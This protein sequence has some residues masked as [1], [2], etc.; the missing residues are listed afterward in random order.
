VL[1]AARRAACYLDETEDLQRAGDCLGAALDPE[2]LRGPLPA[3]NDTYKGFGAGSTS[4]VWL[5]RVIGV[6]LLPRKI[7]VEG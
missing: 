3:S 2:P 5:R 7:F 4:R 1:K 6:E